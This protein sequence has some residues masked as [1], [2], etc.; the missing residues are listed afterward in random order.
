MDESASA[1]SFWAVVTLLQFMSLKITQYPR[2]TDIPFCPRYFPKPEQEISFYVLDLDPYN[3]HSP[4]LN[5]TKRRQRMHSP[6]L[7]SMY[8]PGEALQ[9]FLSRSDYLSCQWGL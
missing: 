9:V 2:Y 4:S 8:Q 5:L 7:R 1:P 6:S 3:L